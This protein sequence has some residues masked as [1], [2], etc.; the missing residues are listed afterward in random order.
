MRSRARGNRGNEQEGWGEGNKAV[1][2]G[3]KSKEL[4]ILKVGGILNALRTQRTSAKLRKSWKR[5]QQ[6]EEARPQRL[7]NW[8]DGNRFI[9]DSGTGVWFG[10]YCLFSFAFVHSVKL[11]LGGV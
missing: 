8:R 3:R 11:L 4:K 9:L 10:I 1:A 6:A 2:L 7:L 5:E